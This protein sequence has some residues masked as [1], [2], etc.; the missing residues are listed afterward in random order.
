MNTVVLSRADCIRMLEK[1]VSRMMGG[2]EW[3]AANVPDST[4]FLSSIT[5]ERKAPD[6]VARAIETVQQSR[7]QDDYF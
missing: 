7:P 4:M 1:S 6:A 3:Q 2:G 5:F